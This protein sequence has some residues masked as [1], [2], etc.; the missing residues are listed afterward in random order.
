MNIPLTKVE[1]GSYLNLHI[2]RGD[3]LPRGTPSSD[4]TELYRVIYF[5]NYVLRV[6]QQHEILPQLLLSLA[7]GLDKEDNPPLF[8]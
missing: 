2:S 5:L 1:F 7:S 4:F 8:L 3:F 6:T